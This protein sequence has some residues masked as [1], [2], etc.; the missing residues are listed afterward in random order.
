MFF[1]SIYQKIETRH[2]ILRNTL[3][4]A[5]I[6]YLLEKFFYEMT[7]TC[8]SAL[9][10]YLLDVKQCQYVYSWTEITSVMIPLQKNLQLKK[11]GAFVA[12]FQWYSHRI[13]PSY[14]FHD[15]RISSIGNSRVIVT[16]VRII[17]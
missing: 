6:S 17:C 3:I 16:V 10:I 14:V 7:R 1:F 2:Y 11:C 8:L 12:R 4:I 13:S 15:C 5:R 9:V